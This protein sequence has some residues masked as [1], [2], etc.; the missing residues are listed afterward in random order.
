[1]TIYRNAENQAKEMQLFFDHSDIVL[2]VKS[3]FGETFVCR[4]MVMAKP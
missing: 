3:A 1:M 4:Q 2:G